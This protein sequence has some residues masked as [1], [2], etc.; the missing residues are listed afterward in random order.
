MPFTGIFDLSLFIRVVGGSIRW[1]PLTVDDWSD[2]IRR[3]EIR[4]LDGSVDLRASEDLGG[5][6]IEHHLRR[7]GA[8]SSACEE[9]LL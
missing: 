5:H 3:Q 8:Q 1:G 2:G 7:E 4:Q 6:P 9:K